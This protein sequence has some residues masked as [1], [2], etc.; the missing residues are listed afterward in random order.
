M[1]GDPPPQGAYGLHF[2]PKRHIEVSESFFRLRYAE[3][4]GAA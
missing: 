1:Y 2:Q 4:P 3:N